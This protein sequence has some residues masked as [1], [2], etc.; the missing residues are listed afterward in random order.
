M[1]SVWEQFGISEKWSAVNQRYFKEW[2]SKN[3]Q[4]N[5]RSR[6]KLLW[7]WKLN[8]CEKFR[9]LKAKRVNLK[10]G[11]SRKQSKRKFPKSK[12]FLNLCAYQAVWNVRFS[13]NLA[14]FVFLKYP[15]WYSLLLLPSIY[16][17]V[18]LR[19]SDQELLLKTWS[20]FTYFKV[21]RI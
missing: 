15:F 11:V 4:K 20:G 14:C 12:H 8:S 16:R 1:L 2:L 21:L 6:V 7:N 17:K 19:N 13:E 5:L 3:F 9:Q 10:T 18:I